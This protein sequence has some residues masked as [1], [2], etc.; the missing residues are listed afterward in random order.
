VPPSPIPFERQPVGLDD[1][2]CVLNPAQ[3]ADLERILL[4]TLPARRLDVAV[5]F[6]GLKSIY[7]A[8]V[9]ADLADSES[10]TRSSSCYR[11]VERQSRFPMGA[12][13]RLAKVFGVPAELLL[14]DWMNSPGR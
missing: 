14:L 3:A 5:A 6:C 12:A 13:F 9:M 7:E 10:P 11:W 4:M 1:I 8:F 2:Y